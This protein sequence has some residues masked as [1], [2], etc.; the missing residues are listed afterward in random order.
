[1]F[2]RYKVEKKYIKLYRKKIILFK[3]IHLYYNLCYVL[4]LIIIFNKY[5][6]VQ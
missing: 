4:L 2:V 5:C 1:M 6:N 3:K